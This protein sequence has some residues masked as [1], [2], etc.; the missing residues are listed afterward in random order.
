MAIRRVVRKVDWGKRTIKYRKPTLA[1]KREMERV[2][3]GILIFCDHLWRGDAS[4]LDTSPRD[5]LADGIAYLLYVA[6]DCQACGL[7]LHDEAFRGF[8]GNSVAEWFRS[9][10]FAEWYCEGAA[11]LFHTTRPRILADLVI[12]QPKKRRRRNPEA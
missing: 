1:F 7:G 5:T 9:R 2:A 12:G 3:Q 4:G 8:I 11:N 6:Y 10:G